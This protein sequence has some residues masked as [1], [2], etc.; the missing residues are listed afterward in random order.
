MAKIVL[1]RG[2]KGPQNIP[3]TTQEQFLDANL[4]LQISQREWDVEQRKL[5]SRARQTAISG[6]QKVSTGAAQLGERII[7]NPGAHALHRL[8]KAWT[9]PH[10]TPAQQFSDSLE[11]A[12]NYAGKDGYVV[13]IAPEYDEVEKYDW[14]TNHESMA[15]KE[16]YFFPMAYTLYEIPV[17]QLKEN[18]EAWHMNEESARELREQRGEE[19]FEFRGEG[20]KSMR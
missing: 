15:T 20:G 6:L 17:W 3:D 2:L 9:D 4:S 8:K 18:A 16:G 14:G 7:P 19:D 12:L 13:S 11:V 5:T 1:Y 10:L